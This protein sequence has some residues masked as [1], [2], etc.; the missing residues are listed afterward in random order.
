MEERRDADVLGPTIVNGAPS[1]FR[2]RSPNLFLTNVLGFGRVPVP[3]IM[4]G[5][6]YD[7]AQVVGVAASGLNA[8]FGLNAPEAPCVASPSAA[9]T[10]LVAA[11]AGV[12]VIAKVARS[13]GYR[14]SRRFA[15][16]AAAT[17]SSCERR[18]F[19]SCTDA[20]AEFA[21]TIAHKAKRLYMVPLNVV[22][23]A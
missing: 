13:G 16:A 7:G 11:N 10:V 4:V 2:K 22:R 17:A 23:D 6:V 20:S 5:A 15:F 9:T 8:T 12:V 21:A 1:R 14:L 18:L 3:V 19:K